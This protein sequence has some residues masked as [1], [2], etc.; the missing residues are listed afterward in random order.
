MNVWFGVGERDREKK[1]V[2]CLVNRGI[3]KD[4]KVQR[5]GGNGLL[6]IQD[7]GDISGQCA[8][9]A[10]VCVRGPVYLGSLLMSVAADTAKG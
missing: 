7:H 4:M 5:E 6:A 9:G 8:A 2:S 1:N 10:H 3:S